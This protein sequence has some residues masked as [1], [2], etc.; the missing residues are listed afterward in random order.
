MFSDTHFHFK[1]MTEERGV[2][3]VDTLSTMATRNCF[4]GLDIGTKAGD[5][6]GRQLAVENVLPQF[7]TPAL[8][9]KPVPLCILPPESGPM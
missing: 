1:M 9:I 8:Q 4:F 6:A 3:G 5:L 7:P 2:D